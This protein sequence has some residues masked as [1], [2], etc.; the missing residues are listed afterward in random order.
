M[1]LCTEFKTLIGRYTV[2]QYFEARYL[3]VADV[4]FPPIPTQGVIHVR[5]LRC[6]DLVLE[7]GTIIVKNI[8]SLDQTS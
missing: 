1:T 4:S 5:S 8:R 7:Q 2:L 3:K 6:I